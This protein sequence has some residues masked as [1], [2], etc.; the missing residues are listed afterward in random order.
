MKRVYLACTL[1]KRH[2]ILN[3]LISIELALL[4]FVFSVTFN[5]MDFIA[6]NEKILVDSK[7]LNSINFT[8]QTVSDY[9]VSVGKNFR[10]VTEDILKITKK[11]DFVLGV[12][13]FEYA[14]ARTVSHQNNIELL[15][16]DDK[17]I[18]LLKV[19]LQNG[20]WFSQETGKNDAVPVVVI[21]NRSNQYKVGDIIDVFQNDK[22]FKLEIIGSTDS[23]IGDLFLP[24]GSR[25]YLG[26]LSKLFAPIVQGET[27]FIS[28]KTPIISSRHNEFDENMMIYIHPNAS[29]ESVNVLQKE[30]S[31][32]GQA[33]IVE[34]MIK[35]TQAETHEKNRKDYANF[36]V[37]CIVV[38]IG[39]FSISVLNIERQM[40]H[41]SIWIINGLSVQ[42]VGVI[43]FLY[44][45]FVGIISLFLY[46]A[47]ITLAYNAD[48]RGHYYLYYIKLNHILISVFLIF[49]LVILI[50]LIF[51]K[52]ISKKGVF[53]YYYE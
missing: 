36:F 14:T 48:G 24:Q 32:Y 34:D 8:A 26:N 40:R 23:S 17:T 37:L 19:P 4:F 52:N 38:I 42:E 12:S 10:K 9:S 35:K 30:L 13:L 44:Q 16:Y 53:E 21:S 25:N 2:F 50:L 1:F 18:E 45:M 7:L 27:I 29:E 6:R 20:K 31:L 33:D 22:T 28:R 11:K 41:F 15:L 5:R 46:F 39:F 47:F 3:F 43:Y 49:V 51:L